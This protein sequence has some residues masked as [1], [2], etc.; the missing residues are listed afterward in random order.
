VPRTIALDALWVHHA[1][2]CIHER[3]ELI[4]ERVKG[5][6]GVPP[7]L[8]IDDDDEHG[9]EHLFTGSSSTVVMIREEE[10]PTAR[11]SLDDEDRQDFV[12]SPIDAEYDSNPDPLSLSIENIVST[13]T[14]PSMTLSSSYSGNLSLPS[15]LAAPSSLS[16]SPLIAEA[17][18]HDISEDQ[19]EPEDDLNS[20]G[21]SDFDKH[22][23]ANQEDNTVA[24]S[25]NEF[26]SQGTIQGLKISTFPLQHTTAPFPHVSSTPS[27]NARPRSL[28]SSSFGSLPSS[29]SVSYDPV[30][31]RVPGN[32]LFPSNFARLAIGPTLRAK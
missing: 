29:S 18:L 14:P 16:H 24:K 1:R 5:A 32:P 12:S 4:W 10:V 27:P 22:T 20:S 31:D 2:A 11:D 6:L 23:K 25:L 7:E 17:G 21:N 28:R 3:S 13:S 19:E 30:G 8:D 26:Q 9:R 15:S